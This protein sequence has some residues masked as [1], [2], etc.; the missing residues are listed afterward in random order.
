MTELTHM[1]CEAC[2]GGV[3]PMAQEEAREM[4][5]QV[6]EWTLAEDAKSIDRAYTFKDFVEAFAFLTKV[7]AL[8]ES[9]GHH[10]NIW[11]S[12]NKVKLELSTHSIS[13]LSKNDFILATKIDQL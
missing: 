9:E 5:K 2:E 13:G 7:A 11:N 12:W 10:P 3:A 4:Q 6:P 1:H 8:A